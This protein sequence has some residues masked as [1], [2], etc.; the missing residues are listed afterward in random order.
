MPPAKRTTRKT[1]P[2]PRRIR[3]LAPILAAALLAFAL[4]TSACLPVRLGDPAESTTRP[5]LNGAW[6]FVEDTGEHML[7]L[8]RSYDEHTHFVQSFSYDM[9]DGEV[10][11]RSTSLA[12]AWLTEI[13]GHTFG[14]LEI[15]DPKHFVGHKNRSR[16]RYV[17]VRLDLEGDRLTVRSTDPKSRHFEDIKTPEQARRIIAEHVEDESIYLEPHT[18]KKLGKDHHEHIRQVLKAFHQG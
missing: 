10:Q 2:T 13:E 7:Y 3:L 15:L 6:L 12:K 8:V 5:R 14:T 9:E 11:P 16:I 18:M 1:L 17:V 4:L